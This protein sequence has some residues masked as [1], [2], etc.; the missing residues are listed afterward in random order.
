MNHNPKRILDTEYAVT[1]LQMMRANSIT[2]LV[3]VDQSDRYLGIVH[4]HDIIREGII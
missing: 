1:A 3:V 2:Q 4:I